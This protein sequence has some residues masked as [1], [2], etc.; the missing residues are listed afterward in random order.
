MGFSILIRSTVV[1]HLLV[2]VLG[3]VLLEHGGQ[4]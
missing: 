2:E 3:R 1:A 4:A